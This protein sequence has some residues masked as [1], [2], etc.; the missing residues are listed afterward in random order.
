MY[1]PHDLLIPAST[2]G[3][4]DSYV[5][6]FLLHETHKEVLSRGDDY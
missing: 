2:E 5:Q 6:T 3:Q 4:T 1:V